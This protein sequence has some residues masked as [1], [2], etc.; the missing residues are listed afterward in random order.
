MRRQ[1]IIILLFLAVALTSC[2]PGHLGGN[3]IAF[4]RDGHL[5]TIDPDG[6]DA[7]EVAAVSGGTVKYSLGSVLNHALMR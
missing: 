5:W 6:A 4:V 7:F 2:S 1:R 3:E